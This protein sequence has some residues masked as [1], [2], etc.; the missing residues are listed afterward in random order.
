M[1]ET[2]SFFSN[3]NRSGMGGMKI[4]SNPEA[5]S[6]I[7][8]PQ[9][10]IFYQSHFFYST[11]GEHRTYKFLTRFSYFIVLKKITIFA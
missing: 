11:K 10:L 1:V 2:L 6:Q 5:G 8:L 3:S 7:L 4:L 9:F